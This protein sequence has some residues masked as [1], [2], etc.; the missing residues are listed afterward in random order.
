MRTILCYGDS[1]TWGSNPEDM[2]R[3]DIHTR[4]P[5]VMR[6][7]LGEDYVVIEEGLSGRTTVWED[8]LDEGRNGRAYLFPCLETHKPID[9]VILM[10]G[11][12]DLKAHFN[13]SAEDVASGV[14]ILVNIIQLSQTDP[15]ARAPR[16]LLVA[17]PVVGK[18]SEFALSFDKARKKSKMFGLFFKQVADLHGCD[19]LDASKLIKSSPLDGIHFDA[20]AHRVLGKAIAEHV[21]QIFE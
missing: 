7:F 1:N 10:L 11:T 15:A 8:P 3:F 19:F 14:D 16:I 12:N 2:T 6:D 13:L 21:L 9:L 18:L 5:G 17:P 4:W 20:D